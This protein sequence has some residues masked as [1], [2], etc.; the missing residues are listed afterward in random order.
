MLIGGS[1]GGLMATVA[2]IDG[3]L[4]VRPFLRVLVGG[5]CLMAQCYRFGSSW[6]LPTQIARHV[7]Q[8]PRTS[9]TTQRLIS[10]KPKEPLR[11]AKQPAS[12]TSKKSAS[13]S[14]TFSIARPGEGLCGSA[15]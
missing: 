12:N 11:S 14:D 6:F 15:A 8:A 10:R 2:I 7:N 5:G 3:Q 4:P 13:I 9:A 1:H